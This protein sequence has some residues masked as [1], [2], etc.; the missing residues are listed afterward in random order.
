MFSAK[1]FGIDFFGFQIQ[2]FGASVSSHDFI[3]RCQIVQ[4]GGVVG[5]FSAKHFGTDFFG[6]QKEWLGASAISHA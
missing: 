1:H 3:Q 6:F 5:M 2:R 4:R